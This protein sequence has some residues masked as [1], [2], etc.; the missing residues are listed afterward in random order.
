MKC[1][2]SFLDAANP[3]PNVLMAKRYLVSD[4][5]CQSVAQ[6]AL[7]DASDTGRKGASH[8]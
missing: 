8:F 3:N 5:R 7:K 1:S 6:S 2:V 4:K